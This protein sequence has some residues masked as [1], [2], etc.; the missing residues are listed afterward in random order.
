MCLEGIH[1]VVDREVVEV[2][3]IDGS[4]R[5]ESDRVRADESVVGL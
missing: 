3:G 1:H 4:D 2:I 5:E